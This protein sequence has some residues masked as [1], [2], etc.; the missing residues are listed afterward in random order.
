MTG[1]GRYYGDEILECDE[2]DEVIENCRN[3]QKEFKDGGSTVCGSEEDDEPIH[4]CSGRC[5]MDMVAS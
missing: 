4:F 5:F 2:C 1:T 3:C